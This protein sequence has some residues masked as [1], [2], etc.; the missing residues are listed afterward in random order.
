[1]LW[2]LAASET[3]DQVPIRSF[4]LSSFLLFF[5][6]GE[7]GKHKN[8]SPHLFRVSWLLFSQSDGILSISF[9]QTFKKKKQEA[10][11]THQVN[12]AKV[13]FAQ[14]DRHVAAIRTY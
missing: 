4:L 13:L 2:F 12:E 10:T 3:C 9:C 7:R 5:F 11:G 1:M 14:G 8:T 6:R